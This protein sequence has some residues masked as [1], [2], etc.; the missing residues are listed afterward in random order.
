M[1]EGDYNYFLEKW[2]AAHAE[3]EGDEEDITKTQIV[4]EKKKTREEQK[5]ARAQ[6]KELK[7]LEG[8]LHALEEEIHSIDEALADPKTYEDHTVALELSEKRDTLQETLDA[9]YDKWFE[10]SDE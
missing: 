1:V 6:K 5:R 7:A 8:E 9:L 2:E 10:L 4:K 3:E